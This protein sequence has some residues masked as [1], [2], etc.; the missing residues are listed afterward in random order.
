MPPLP[1]ALLSPSPTLI[2]SPKPHPHHRPLPLPLHARCSL[3]AAIPTESPPARGG[4]AITKPSPAELSRTIMELAS[5]GTLSAL[6]PDGWPL[7]VG[8][9]FVADAGGAPVLCLH[10][11]DGSVASDA[12]S[13][14]HVMFEQSG[15]RT[16][17]CTL[18]GNVVK[19]SDEMLL[20][21]LRTRWEKKFGE[22][23]DADLL[24]LISVERIFHREDFK[25][26]GL[27]VAPSEYLNAEPDP[28]R[29]FAEKIVD[30]MNSRHAEDVQRLCNVYVESGFQVIDAKMIWVDRLG[31]DLH[32]CSEK[33]VFAVRIPFPREVVDEK[34]AKSS[35]NLMAHL[36][37]EVDKNYVA[38]DFE[39][40]NSL[41][42][43]R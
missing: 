34:G 30:E 8:A 7:G 20:K 35:F 10:S 39:K 29:N 24:H 26:D 19:P 36:A 4:L 2:L 16:P 32:V 1:H 13:S 18:L 42:M 28:L 23:I 12:R 21:K 14:F 25:E 3:R 15:S 41:K 27:W 43:I 40:V 17:Q 37:W 5:A 33:G 9:R 11:R 38:P 22:E 6:T 31:F